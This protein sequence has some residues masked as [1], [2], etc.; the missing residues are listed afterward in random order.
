M[1]KVINDL[2]SKRERFDYNITFRISTSAKEALD[3][4][5]IQISQVCREALAKELRK[6]INNS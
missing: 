3:A 6:A 2:K 5:D 1:R 4:H